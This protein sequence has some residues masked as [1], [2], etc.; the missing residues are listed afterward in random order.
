[1]TDEG[2]PDHSDDSTTESDPT[3][4]C[5]GCRTAVAR[6]DAIIRVGDGP[7]VFTNPMGFVYD[8]VLFGRARAMHVHG[9]PTT[10]FTWFTG[11]AWQV[12]TCATCH[13]HLG[14]RFSATDDATPA[15]FWGLLR[16]R[17]AR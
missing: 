3:V 7:T 5:A 10:E 8:L 13:R 15:S 2:S 14:W 17:L 4:R 11:Y 6:T 1:M 12:A 16:D 9:P